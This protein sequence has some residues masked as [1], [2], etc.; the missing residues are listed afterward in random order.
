MSITESAV[1]RRANLMAHVG[2]EGAL[3]TVGVFCSFLGEA[4]FLRTCF[5]DL[6]KMIAMP[7]QF[8]IAVSDFNQHGVEGIG[9][10]ADFVVREFLSTLGE[11]FGVSDAVGRIGQRK[12]RAQQ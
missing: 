5:D 11:V 8:L 4:Q 12:Q 3:C 1:H 2:E 7:R 9:K 6:F 10:L